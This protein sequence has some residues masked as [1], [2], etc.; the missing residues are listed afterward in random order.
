MAIYTL[1]KVIL[2]RVTHAWL[3]FSRILAFHLFEFN[4]DR[5]LMRYLSGSKRLIAAAVGYVF[6]FGM[7]LTTPTILAQESESSD[8]EELEEVLVTGSRIVRTNLIG[9]SP[10]I[11]VDSEE[12]EYQGNVRIED[13]MRNLP[14]VWSG[15]NTGQSNGATGTATLNL[16]NLGAS[17]SLVL[18]NGRRLPAGS[19]IGGG[20]VADLNQIPG[21]MLKSVEILTGGASATY[22]SDAVAGVINFLMNDSFQGIS[23]NAQTSWYSHGNN[24][25]DVQQIVRD[26]GFPVAD[27]A[28]SDGFM[29]V[30]SAVIGGNLNDGRGN[31]TAYVTYRDIESVAQSE[32][33]YSSC[34]L[35]NAADGCFGSSTIPEGRITNFANPAHVGFDYKV[36]GSNFVPRAGTLFNYGPLNYFQR[37]DERISF[38]VFAHYD[39]S[40]RFEGYAE[41]MFKDDRTVSQIAPSGAFFVTSQMSCSNPFLSDAQYNLLTEDRLSPEQRAALNEL[42]GDMSGAERE[43]FLDGAFCQNRENDHIDAYIGRRNVEGGPRQHDLR[44]TSYRVVLGLRGDINDTWDFDVSLQ[45]A[46]VSM[47]NTYLNDL[48]TSRIRRALDATRTEDGEIVCRSVL[49]GSDLNCVPWN[50]FTT[51]AVTQ[52]TID[53]LVLPLFARG[54]TDQTV[55][56]GFVRGDFAEQG[57]K[58]PSADEAVALVAG[59][60][61]RDEA[62]DFVPDSGYRLGEGAGQGGATNAVGGGYDVTELFVE[63]SVPVTSGAQM[64][65]DVT[66]DLGYRFSDY[67]TGH[68][69]HTWGVRYSHA[70]LDDYRLRGSVQRAIRAAGVRELFQPQG[71]NLFDMGT[72]PCGGPVGSNGRTESGRTLEECARS[73]VMESQFGN[74]QHSPAGQYNFLQGGNPDVAPEESMTLSVGFVWNPSF[75][76][77][78]STTLDLYD[79]EVEKG[80]APLTPEFVLNQCLDGDL[81]RCQLVKRNPVRGDLWIG[82]EVNSSGHIVALLDN[83]AIENVRGFDMEVSYNFNTNNIGAF[84]VHSVTGFILTWDQQELATAESVDCNGTWGGVCGVPTP[85]FQNNVRVVWETPW[86]QLE[87]SSLWRHVGGTEDLGPGEVDLDAVNYLDLGSV[88]RYGDSTTIRGGVTNILDAAPPIAGNSAGP[89]IGGNGNIFPGMYDALGRYTFLNVGLSF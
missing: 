19:P 89:S 36:E 50:I 76:Q 74:I 13:M 37:P 43:A 27:D 8:E 15:Q 54:T 25:D 34:A 22:G 67:S 40:P 5:T 35:N 6:T 32:R 1:F 85:E 72:D 71:F 12:L 33:D 48:S 83:L 11:Q 52:D 65:D 49:D 69:T 20:G 62:L 24:N 21:S 82:S 58:L 17:R 57:L 41:M 44:H 64:A 45:D 66:I 75:L 18:I 55:I 38:G 53:Y 39:I 42:T 16:R 81:A 60:E 3:L 9:S 80:I 68:T 47:E 29:N 70:F 2:R 56:T 73:G 31:V 88:W 63:A 51:G 87:V 7:L 10:V 79:I 61:I 26:H 59:L 77:G 23:L 84:S 14:Q 86:S 30:F 78:L 28:T 46:E 4:Y